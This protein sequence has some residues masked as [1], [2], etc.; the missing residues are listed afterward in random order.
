VVEEVE[1]EKPKNTCMQEIKEIAHL[2]VDKRMRWLL[3]E[4]FWTGISMSVY[5][6]LLIPIIFSTLP[7]DDQNVQFQKA[8]FSM[9][10]LGIG[11]ILGGIYT[12]YIIDKFGNKVA[13]YSNIL[14]VIIQTVFALSY[15]A[16]GDYGWLAYVMTFTWGFSDNGVNTHLSEMMGFEFEDSA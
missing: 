5:S 4:I 13:T 14:T 16:I 11:E 3:P 1:E 10:S 8:M 15:I 2:C 7:D 6:G 9:T 12:G